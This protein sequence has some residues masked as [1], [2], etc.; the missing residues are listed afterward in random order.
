MDEASISLSMAV[1]GAIR[2]RLILLAKSEQGMA[3]PVAIFAMIASFA[4]ASAAILSS[5]TAQ[6]GTNRDRDSKSAIAAADAGASVAL[7][8]M[9]RFLGSFKEGTAECISPSGVIQ[10]PQ[11]DGWCPPTASESVGGASFSYQVSAFQEDGPVSVVAVG[12]AD[13]VSRRVKVGLL[14]FDGEEVFANEKLIGETGIDLIGT[15]IIETNMGTNGNIDGDDNADLCGDVRHGVGKTSLEE[16]CGDGV[17]AE[18]NK[19]L[20]QLVLPEGVTT[21]N[22]NCRLVPNC[23]GANGKIDST[24]VDLYFG[25]NGKAKRTSTEPWDQNSRTI[26]VAGNSTLTMGGG[27]Y[28]V[29]RLFLGGKLIMP[30]KSKIRIFFDTPENCKLGNGATQLEIGNNAEITSSAFEA[31]ET[32]DVP[33]FYL[34]GSPSIETVVNL[35]GTPAGSNELVIYA[36]NSGITISGNSTWVGMI[37][38]KS[39]KVNGNPKIESNPGI[40]A[41]AIFYSGIWERT[42]YVECAGGSASPP[43]ASC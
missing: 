38:G 26:N 1:I 18:G 19:T 12:T 6:Q 39:L 15:P 17:L 10:K 20:P 9:N 2:R 11:L 40:E 22:S 25:S 42:H 5:V 8:R 43:D 33:G 27:D 14:S 41:E 7:M 23:I 28:F 13:D 30:A 24:Q 35:K 21:N 16:D 4:F 29:C 34:L 37:A 3:L 31:G 32:F 36:P